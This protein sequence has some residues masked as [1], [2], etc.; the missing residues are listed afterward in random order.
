MKAKIVR[1]PRKLLA[2]SKKYGKKSKARKLVDIL[3]NVNKRVKVF[4][5]HRIEI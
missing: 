3:A 5:N 2:K 1:I 4:H